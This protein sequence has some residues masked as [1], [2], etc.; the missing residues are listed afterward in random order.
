MG[1]TTYQLVQDFFHPPY[2]AGYGNGNAKNL[3]LRRILDLGYQTPKNWLTAG[4]TANCSTGHLE[5]LGGSTCILEEIVV[6]NEN[7]ITCML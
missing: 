3:Q 6:K 5:E 1:Q 4:A 2:F 7:C